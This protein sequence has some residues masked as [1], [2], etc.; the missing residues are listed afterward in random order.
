[1]FS[2]KDNYIYIDEHG[3]NENFAEWAKK[4]NKLCADRDLAIVYPSDTDMQLK[5]ELNSYSKNFGELNDK[6]VLVYEQEL[7]RGG[8]GEIVNLN[9]L[10]SWLV[11]IAIY[12]VATTGNGF[13]KEFGKDLYENTLKKIF[14]RKRNNNKYHIGS[15]MIQVN[16]DSSNLQYIFLNHH[17]ERIKKEAYDNIVFHLTSINKELLKQGIARF[18]WDNENK[19]WEL[20]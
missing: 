3:R 2:K 1:M 7:G 9:L 4:M 15:A 11:P 6:K 18:I 16:L 5:E 12:I 13:F 14:N 8:I 19:K 10:G 17:S 20:L